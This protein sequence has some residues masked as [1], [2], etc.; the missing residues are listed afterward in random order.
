MLQDILN[1]F[2]WLKD[3]IVSVLDF[4]LGLITDFVEVLKIIPGV[5]SVLTSSIAYLP[6]LVQ[7]FAILT[8][9]ISVVYLMA[10]RDTGE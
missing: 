4:G 8:I 3:T 1:I 7:V 6:D 2:V 9:V 5:L 10:G